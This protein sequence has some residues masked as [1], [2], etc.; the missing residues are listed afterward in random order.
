[1]YWAK[2]YQKTF[3]AKIID[4][5][6][7]AIILDETL[8]YATAGNQIHDTGTITVEDQTYQVTN[9]EREE[10]IYFHFVKPKP[11]KILIGSP[12][13]GNIDWERRY[14]VMKAHTA[15]HIVSAIMLKKFN[16]K[17]LHASIKPAVFSVEFAQ[18]ITRKQLEV[19]L[20][21]VNKIFTY[22]SKKVKSHVLNHNEATKRYSKKNPRKNSRRRFS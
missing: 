22:N 17:T 5:K 7:D 13:K 18:R 8:F 21:E 15:Q 10:D 19:V 1:M 2:P 3:T 6:R 4:V 14:S 9:V 11:A 20:Q 12:I 16:K